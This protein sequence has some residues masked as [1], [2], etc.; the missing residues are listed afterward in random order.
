[1]G[2]RAVQVIS[3][4]DILE[5]SGF[6]PP[7][8]R[9]L[10]PDQ[11]NYKAL[12]LQ[13]EGNITADAAGVRNTNA[14][15]ADQQYAAFLRIATETDADLVVTPEY[16]LPWRILQ[17]FIEGDRGPTE[18][19]LWGLGCESVTLDELTAFAANLA[20]KATFI[21]EPLASDSNRFLNPFV[22]MFQTSTLADVDDRR[23]IVLVQFKTCPMGDDQHLE[24]NGLQL[25]TR[26]YR[27]GGTDAQLRLVTLICSDAFAFTEA[28]AAN[29]YDRTLVVHVQLNPNPRQNL[30]RIYRT[31]L[32]QYGGDQTE[33]ITLNWAK[34]IQAQPCN[35]DPCWHNIAGS[36]WYLRPDKFD[37]RDSVLQHNHN[38]GLY[39][40]W[41]HVDRCH[42]LF[43]SYAPAAFLVVGTKVAH[44]KVP[45]PLSRRIGPK[46]ETLYGWSTDLGRWEEADRADDMFSEAVADAGEAADQLKVLA[47]ENAFAVE[48]I[49]AICA[50]YPVS[51]ADWHKVFHLDSCQIDAEEIVR[52]VTFCHDKEKKA[53]TFRRSR[54]MAAQRTIRLLNKSLPPSLSDLAT[55]FHFD[56]NPASPHTNLLSTAQR[57]A[58]AIALDDNHTRRDAEKVRDTVAEYLRR[59]APSAD[60]SIDA[61]QRLHVWYRDDEGNAVLCDP[62][63]YVMYD[64]VHES[65]FDI[66]RAS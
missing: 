51:R 54:L 22:Y 5:E 65:P 55:G 24:V 6:S 1:M 15:L 59:E 21:Y 13:P 16:S 9:A 18:G 12:L 8:L 25:G 42:A 61:M 20:D 31:H 35:G 43:F 27:F 19:K 7:H 11:A 41:L 33:I 45:A 56:W 28:H 63:H 60:E 34:D 57:R 44:L 32:L 58:T 66:G 17:S 64:Q 38:L 37:S 48:R 26:L 2:L 39:Y 10:V 40:T 23:L 14:K 62:H 3:V 46:M 52:R 53:T 30:F 4:D 36:G 29:L 49:L 50:G 47:Q